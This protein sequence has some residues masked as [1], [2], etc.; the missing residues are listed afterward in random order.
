MIE[1]ESGLALVEVACDLVT[2]T[3]G[4]QT[5]GSWEEIEVEA[6]GAPE[7]VA[8]HRKVVRALRK[9]GCKKVG[10]V[11][12]LVRALGD[13]ASAPPEVCVPALTSHP[14]VVDAV[15][16]A[17]ARSVVQ[18]LAH[19]PAVR[20]GADPED[21]H[22]FRVAT[23]RLRSDLRTFRKFFDAETATRVRGELRWLTDQTNTLR[24]LDVLRAWLQLQEEYIPFFDQPAIEVLISRCEREAADQ[25][26]ALLRALG[27]S[28]YDDL[29]HDLIDLRETPPELRHKSERRARQH[30]LRQVHRRRDALEAQMEAMG[31]RSDPGDLHQARIAA[32]RYRAAVEAIVP[33][34]GRAMSRL[35]HALAELQDVLGAV[36]DASVIE[37]WL[38]EAGG[39][40]EA[41]VAGELAAM[42]H[43]SGSSHA[44]RWPDAWAR[45]QR[46]QR[47]A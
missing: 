21:L 31:S 16:H 13:D 22:Q 9:A 44:A 10:A 15:E 25:R 29:L 3:R 6:L 11:P 27:S 41:F 1:D 45:V 38:R 37:D 42:A 30:L 24:D 36:H 40:P 34:S 20:V 33:L 7:G 35:A 2:A 46:R 28:R 12:K 19:D 17:L 14:T 4:R 47:A 18:L 39:T 5:L 26:A 8:A 32:K 23:R 43:A